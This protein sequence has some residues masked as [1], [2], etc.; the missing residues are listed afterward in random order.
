[1]NKFLIHS[2]N[3]PLINSEIFNYSEQVVLF[4]NSGTIEDIDKY[5]HDSITVGSISSKIKTADIIFIKVGLS[6]NYLEYYGLRVA[7][8]IRLTEILSKK[9]LVPIVFIGAESLQFIGQTA[10]LP[11]IFFTEG[12]YLIE[13]NKSD[14][15][16]FISMYSS[17]KIKGL[18][19]KNSFID[20]IKIPSPPNYLSNHSID[21][22]LSILQWSETLGVSGN[23][24]LN[25]LTKDIESMLYYKY[26]I[27]KNN[28][29]KVSQLK[30]GHK[31]KNIT[32]NAKV[33]YVDDE[34]KKGWRFLLNF[35]LNGNNNYQ[36]K[37]FKTL[38]LDYKQLNYETIADKFTH[39]LNKF[40]PDIVILDLR[41][42]DDDFSDN[43]LTKQLSGVKLL[44]IIKKKN[45]GIQVAIFSATNKVWNLLELQNE[46]ADSFLMKTPP[47]NSSYSEI[48]KHFKTE[49]SYLK[50][51]KFIK[52]LIQSC[53]NINEV[54]ENLLEDYE[55]DYIF[56]NF[57]L[58]LKS[59]NDINIINLSNINLKKINTLNITFLSFFNFIESFKNHYFKNNSFLVGQD[60]MKFFCYKQNNGN[61]Q[62]TEDIEQAWTSC[63]AFMFIEYFKVLKSFESDIK[64]L[65]D[66]NEKRNDFIHRKLTAFSE[67]ELTQIV[68][69]SVKICKNLKP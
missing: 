46:G 7:Y 65:F 49:L 68:N 5:I 27:L 58:E 29:S 38:E 39:C 43:I 63:I 1:M 42:C 15:S 61:I 45:P 10:E 16:R 69:L 50:E 6:D 9:S 19:H 2:Q 23:L 56:Y 13:D 36:N 48:I 4:E 66:L 57:L 34:W 52:K 12:I 41:L 17:N 47:K 40:D 11:E 3:T 20:R 33:L 28:S 18:T 64:V 67:E 55:D 32:L 14:V 37:N 53:H 54:V 21:N 24:E 8:H 26:L 62:K 35:V 22:E 59:K 60:Q 44:K 25:D 30:S 51:K 31:N